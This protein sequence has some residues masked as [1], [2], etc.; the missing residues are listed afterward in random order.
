M[1]MHAGRKLSAFVVVVLMATGAVADNLSDPELHEFTAGTPARASEVNENF[2]AVQSA[3]ND[4]DA[5]ITTNAGDIADHETRIGD[6]E[7][8]SFVPPHTHDGADIL[9]GEGS[10]LDADLLDG[11]DSSAFVASGIADS[12]T[13]VSAAISTTAMA[14]IASI[15][16]NPS[17]SAGYATV[18]ASCYIA[19]THA[20]G[21]DS[22]FDIGIDDASGTGYDIFTSV[23]I[24]G[25]CPSGDYEIPVS[26]TFGYTVTSGTTKTFYLKGQKGS[27]SS[28]AATAY[29]PVITAMYFRAQM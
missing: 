26:L 27:S 16:I 15:S 23:K 5:R 2:D 10:G 25:A 17:G 6:I 29:Q 19:W 3:V 21:T 1:S 22:E 7:S 12:D 24:P 14:E 20:T 28:P 18:T 11:F 4:N 8:G 13:A 9:G